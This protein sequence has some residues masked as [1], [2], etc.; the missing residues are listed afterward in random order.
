MH[1]V[2]NSVITTEYMLKE[3]PRTVR[4]FMTGLLRGWQDALASEN[5]EKAVATIQE[6]DKDTPVKIIRRQRGVSP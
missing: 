4:K 5:E 2:A 1:F 6:F 3:R